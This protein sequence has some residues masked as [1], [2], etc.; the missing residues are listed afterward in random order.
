MLAIATIT[1][2]LINL[3]KMAKS[4]TA[5]SN[6]I[7]IRKIGFVRSHWTMPVI[8]ASRVGSVSTLN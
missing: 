1:A 4:K 3:F 6:R 2:I 5:T 8:G 7:G